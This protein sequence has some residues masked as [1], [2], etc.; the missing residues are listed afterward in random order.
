MSDLLDTADIARLLEITREHCT[1]RVTKRPDFPAPAVNLSRRLRRWRKQDIAAWLAKAKPQCRQ[2]TP[3][4]T[5]A[6]TA[7]DRGAQTPATS[8]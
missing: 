4:S 7:V 8:A 2:Q 1:D 6:T 3:G 5:P